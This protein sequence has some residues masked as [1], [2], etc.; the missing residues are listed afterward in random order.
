MPLYHTR[1]IFYTKYQKRL[2][3]ILKNPHLYW[4]YNYNNRFFIWFYLYI[5][6]FSHSARIWIRSE[7]RSVDIT[8]Q[9]LPL[10]TGMLQHERDF[11]LW[12]LF[13]EEQKEVVGGVGG[14]WKRCSE[15]ER[16]YDRAPSI[17]SV[18]ETG[19]VGEMR[20]KR[21]T[22]KIHRYTDMKQDKKEKKKEWEASRGQRG[23]AGSCPGLTPRNTRKKGSV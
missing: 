10:R 21:S 11:A 12:F 23:R 3:K 14:N 6:L 18:G 4:Q 13:T 17:V 7:K 19:E 2:N 9:H 20:I 5:F 16:L 1:Y 8:S 22:L 15:D